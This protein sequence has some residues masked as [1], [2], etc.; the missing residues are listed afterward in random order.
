[1]WLGDARSLDQDV[2][3]HLLLGEADDLLHQ[4]RLQGAADA[5][6]LHPNHRLVALDQVGVVDQVLVN[7]ELR[8]V[9]DNDRALELLIVMFC[10]EDVFQ[11]SCL[12]RAKEATKQG[13]GNQVFPRCCGGL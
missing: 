1:M 5:T 7:V 4:V 3:E 8:H 13:D 12:A 2:V 6:V 9:V 10:L 11:Q